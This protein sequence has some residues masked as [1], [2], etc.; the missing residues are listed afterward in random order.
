MYAY[1]VDIKKQGMSCWPHF[2]SNRDIP[3]EI[4]S[5]IDYFTCR[6]IVLDNDRVME[7]DCSDVESS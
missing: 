5:E 3:S 4:T 7:Y 1:P 2:N 6:M